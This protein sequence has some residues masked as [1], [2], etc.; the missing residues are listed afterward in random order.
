MKSLFNY[1]ALI[2]LLTSCISEKKRAEICASCPIVTEVVTVEKITS[3]DTALYISKMGKDLSF[4][5]NDSDCCVL[6]N[7]L[8]EAMA[9][10]N[11]TIK[12]KKDGIKSSIFK[13]KAK[14]KIV[15]RCEA[16]SLKEVIKGLRTVKITDKKETKVIEKLCELEHRNWLDC[17][18]RKWLWI[19]LIVLSVFG[20]WKFGPKLLKLIKFL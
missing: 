17:L 16:D 5:A 11:D 18:A 15:F 14:G 13:D 4:N 20:L 8:L 9:E 3:F 1:L 6:V 12:A 2:L 19:S 10:S 7:A